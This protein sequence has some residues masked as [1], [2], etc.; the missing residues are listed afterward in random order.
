MNK[1][2]KGLVNLGLATAP[3]LKKIDPKVV[4]DN[5]ERVASLRKTAIAN[6]KIASRYPYRGLPCNI[7]TDDKLWAVSG[8]DGKG[9]GILEWCYDA[10]D[11]QR[12]LLEM[13]K[14]AQFSGLRAHPYLED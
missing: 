1:L 3:M 11:A 4:I 14:Y 9:G 2:Q 12:I 5:T 6:G 8:I 13:R 7:T 10:A